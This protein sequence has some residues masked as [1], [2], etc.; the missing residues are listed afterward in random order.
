MLLLQHM[1]VAMATCFYNKG[2]G[3]RKEVPQTIDVCHLAAC[4]IFRE[5]LLLCRP[6]FGMS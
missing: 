3:R 6:A 1:D 5:E 4:R 2:R